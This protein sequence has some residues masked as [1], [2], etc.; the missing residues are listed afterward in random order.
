M[1]DK[2]SLDEK[3][4]AVFHRAQFLMDDCEIDEDSS[5]IHTD[6]DSMSSPY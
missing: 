1:F 4:D 5:D 6:N 3:I 2:M